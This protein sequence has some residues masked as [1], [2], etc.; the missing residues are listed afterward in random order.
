MPLITTK[1]STFI[2]K[3]NKYR[4]MVEF[5]QIFEEMI[6]AEKGELVMADF[7]DETFILFGDNGNEP[8]AAIEVAMITDVYADYGRNL[9]EEVL[10]RLTETVMKYTQIPEDRIFAFYRN[11]PLWCYQRQDVLGNF[12]KWGFHM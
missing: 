10:V 4:M 12:M 11:S 7:Y 1:T 2:N 8:C 5:R 9:L 6:P 3:E